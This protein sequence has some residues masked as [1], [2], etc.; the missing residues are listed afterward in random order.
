M[1][2]RSP[3]L[4]NGDAEMCVMDDGLSNGKTRIMPARLKS[5]TQNPQSMIAGAVA[6]FDRRKRSAR[7]LNPRHPVCRGDFAA[8]VFSGRSA[9]LGELPGEPTAHALYKFALIDPRLDRSED[10]ARSPVMP[11]PLCLV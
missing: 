9:D 8:V 10:F 1:P 11:L 6:L 5:K 3:S 7:S 2:R 4:R